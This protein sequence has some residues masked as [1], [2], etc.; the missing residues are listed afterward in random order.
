M[1][2]DGTAHPSEAQ[3]PLRRAL[4]T[5][6]GTGIGRAITLALAA[7]GMDCCLVGR[8]RASL[9]AVAAEAKGNRSQVMVVVGD[10]SREDDRRAMVRSCLDEWGTLDVLVNNAGY[11]V[12]EPVLHTSEEAW[13]DVLSVNLDGASLLS[14]LALKHMRT[15]S[16]GRIVYIGSVYGMVALNSRFYRTKWQDSHEGGPI[17]GLPYAAAKGGLRAVTRDLAVAAGPWG[18]TVNLVMPGMIQ[19]EARRIDQRREREFAEHTPVGR[20]GTP[21]EVAHAVRF[22]VSEEAGFV[23]GA[24]LMVDGGWSIW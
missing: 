15:Q 16:W 4:I 1:R 12:V 9:E 8:T 22:L 11:S 13:R 24:E 21:Q 2:S 5:G 7:A 6:A 10:V 20:L 19:T 17:R 14:V 3:S 18:V 23:T